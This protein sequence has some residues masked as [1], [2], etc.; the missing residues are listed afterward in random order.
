MMS[1]CGSPCPLSLGEL[2]EHWTLAHPEGSCHEVPGNHSDDK[3]LDQL[4]YATVDYANS[5]APNWVIWH[6]V[7]GGAFVFNG[8]RSCAAQLVSYLALP[9]TSLTGMPCTGRRS[10][11]GCPA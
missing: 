2:I 10:K 11:E 4:E 9:G 6:A 3:A 8:T 7:K 1:V 5:P